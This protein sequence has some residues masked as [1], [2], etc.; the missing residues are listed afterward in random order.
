[1]NEEQVNVLILKHLEGKTT[2]GEEAVLDNWLKEDERHHLH[3]EQVRQVAAQLGKMDWALE[4]DRQGDWEKV[5]SRIEVKGGRSAR[6]LP[7]QYLRIAVS[8]AALLAF[9]WLFYIWLKTPE[10]PRMAEQIIVPRGETRQI[11]LPDGSTVRLN[12]DSY[13]AIG[14]SFGKKE[15]RLE[16]VGE[17]YFEVAEDTNKPFIVDIGSAYVRVLGTTFQ[18]RAYKGSSKASV[19]VT[20]GLVRFRSQDSEGLELPAGQAA[21]YDIPNAEFRKAPY[22]PES[23]LAWLDRRLVFKNTPLQE[24]FLALERW[25]DVQ[26][27]DQAG[28]GDSLYSDTVNYD[29]PADNFFQ[30]LSLTQ[31]ISFRK[32][33]QRILLIRPE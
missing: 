13:L 33:G 23:A 32:D 1:M 14:P 18:L 15:R 3:F 24:I 20:K 6:L 29:D 9:G 25:Y 8:L 26:I 7:R 19:T 30:R 31:G 5:K 11:T 12:A 21:E 28:I 2:A 10:T 16:L 17:A 4:L 22:D 27:V